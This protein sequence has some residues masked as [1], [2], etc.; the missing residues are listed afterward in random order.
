MVFSTS[1][2]LDLVVPDIPESVEIEVKWECY[3]AEQ[4]LA[5]SEALF[6]PDGGKVD[7][8]SGSEVSLGPQA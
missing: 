7:Q 3:L 8:P 1:R 6:G 5:E 2:V 4:A